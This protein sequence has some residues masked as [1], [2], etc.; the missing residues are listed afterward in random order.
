MAGSS[1]VR[2]QR[3]A[4]AAQVC[5]RSGSGARQGHAVREAQARGRG[6]SGAGWMSVPMRIGGDFYVACGQLKGPMAVEES[7]GAKIRYCSENSALQQLFSCKIKT[8]NNNNNNN[9]NNKH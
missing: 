3:A 1:G 8:N 5:G 4:G 9:N 6:S 2:Q 7:Q